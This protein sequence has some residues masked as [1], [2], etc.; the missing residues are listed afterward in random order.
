MDKTA[1]IKS[2]LIARIKDSEDIQFLKALQTIFD[3]S[4]KALYALSP[5]Q[6]ESILIGRKQIKNGQFS[7]N[8]SVISEMKEWL[9]KE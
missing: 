8:E 4:E 6:E 9:V 1:Q 7:S 2:N 5:E 3:T